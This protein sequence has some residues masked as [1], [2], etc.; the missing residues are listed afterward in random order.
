[1]FACTTYQNIFLMS[2][3]YSSWK[4]GIFWARGCMAR[5]QSICE[6]PHLN[7]FYLLCYLQPFVQLTP[8]PQKNQNPPPPKTLGSTQ[9]SW[10]FSVVDQRCK[11][12]ET[13]NYKQTKKKTSGRGCV[14]RLGKGAGWVRWFEES[15]WA[16]KMTDSGEECFTC[17]RVH[18]K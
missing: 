9:L 10:G 3:V 13:A 5:H 6:K 11:K 1:M 14:E 4:A 15:C 7:P 17:S 12:R 16:I 2:V 18:A 8:P